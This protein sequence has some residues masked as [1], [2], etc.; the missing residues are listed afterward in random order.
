MHYW[1]GVHS[2][3]EHFQIRTAKIINFHLNCIIGLGEDYHNLETQ[4]VMA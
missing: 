4:N 1:K 2:S 3:L